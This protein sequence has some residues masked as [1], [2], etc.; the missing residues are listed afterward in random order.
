MHRQLSNMKS[1]ADTLANRETAPALETKALSNFEHWVDKT[2]KLIGR[3][4]IQTFKLVQDWPEHKIERRYKEA[5]NCGPMTKP[6]VR[7]WSLRKK[8]RE[9]DKT[10]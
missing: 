4:Y 2:A 10:Q 3:S 5:V 9:Q 7:W 6:A 1:L 8:E